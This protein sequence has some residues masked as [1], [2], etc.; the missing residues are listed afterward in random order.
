[1]KAQFL[2]SFAVFKHKLHL[3]A[4]MCLHSGT[5]A[6]PSGCGWKQVVEGENFGS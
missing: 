6:V 2:C 1:M 3:N 5:A 4:K